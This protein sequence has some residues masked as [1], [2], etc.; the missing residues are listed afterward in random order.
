MTGSAER[1]N[2][3]LGLRHIVGLGGSPRHRLGF[4]S[5]TGAGVT[6]IASLARDRVNGHML[7]HGDSK[8]ARL[9][10]KLLSLP[11]AGI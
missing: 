10:A 9:L 11:L 8:G 3:V 2:S 5:W 4:G 1:Q 7:R 6:D